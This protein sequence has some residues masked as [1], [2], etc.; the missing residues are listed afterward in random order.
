MPSNK[1]GKRKKT[2]NQNLTKSEEREHILA[3]GLASNENSP[4]IPVFARKT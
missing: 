2:Q 4:Y 3:S 1:T